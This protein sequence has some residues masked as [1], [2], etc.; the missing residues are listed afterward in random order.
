NDFTG[1]QLS[2]GI[3]HNW[4]TMM[5]RAFKVTGETDLA[6]IFTAFRGISRR[7]FIFREDGGKRAFGDTGATVNTGIRVDI[8]PGPLFNWETRNHTFHGTNIDTA[9]VAH[10]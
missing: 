10:A 8:D 6:D 4:V 7:N 1:F 5:I 2:A 9:T 3:Q